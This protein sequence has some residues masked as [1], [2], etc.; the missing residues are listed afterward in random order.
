MLGKEYWLNTL[1]P[2]CSRSRGRK[3][4]SYDEGS[5]NKNFKGNAFLCTHCTED[6]INLYL[7]C[8]ADSGRSKSDYEKLKLIAVSPCYKRFFEGCTLI[9][10]LM[11]MHNMFCMEIVHRWRDLGIRVCAKGDE[12]VEKEIKCHLSLFP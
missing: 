11:T 8:I 5:V 2:F 6:P 1:N 7:I 9:L 3:F 12:G 4:A 10:S